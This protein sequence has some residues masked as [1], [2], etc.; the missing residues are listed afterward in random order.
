MRLSIILPTAGNDHLRNRNFNECL[1]CINEQSFR[2]FE[3]IVVEQALDRNNYYKSS[4][5]LLSYKHIPIKDPENR[6]FNLSWC[7]NVGA[8]EAI[9]E[10]IVLMDS[11]FVFEKDYFKTIS[12]FNGEFAAGA[13][14]YYWSNLEGPTSDFLR[15]KNFDVFRKK[16]GGPRDEVFKFRSM[17]MGCGYGAI[18]VYN[19]NWFWEVF[20]GY[21]ENFFRYGWEDKAATETIKSLLSRNDETM[22]RI[23]YEAAHLNHRGKDVKNM[24]INEM[25]FNRFS[26]MDQNHLVSLI[27]NVGVGKRSI[28]SLI[29]Y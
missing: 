22:L 20:G 13:E 1:K 19:K 23:P 5:P 15:T 14:T 16:G 26:K 4:N 21:N 24:N 2:D 29:N 7:R 17:S 12:E 25:L 3:V 11:D 28:P 27:K 8:R 18:L 9:G 6:G 10:I